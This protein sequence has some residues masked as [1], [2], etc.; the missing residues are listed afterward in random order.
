MASSQSSGS[1]SESAVSDSNSSNQDQQHQSEMPSKWAALLRPSSDAATSAV[2]ASTAAATPA[3]A[4]I[5][6]LVPLDYERHVKFFTMHLRCMPQGYESLDT[7]RMTL[8][9][10]CLSALDVLGALDQPSPHR[11]TNEQLID[12]I[13]AQQVHPYVDA[14]SGEMHYERCGFKGGPAAGGKFDPNNSTG[15]PP[16]E[17]HLYDE[18]HIA[19][20][21]TALCCLRILG[22]TTFSRVNRSALIA[23]LPFLQRPDGSFTST[24]SHRAEVADMRFLYCATAISSMLQDWSGLDR[25]RAAEFIVSSQ[26]HDGALGLW[27][28]CEGHGGSTYCAVASLVLMNRFDRLHAPLSL[29]KW[30]ITRQGTRDISSLPPSLGD[31]G[32]D[33][34]DDEGKVDG[35]YTGRPN[36]DS[37]TC[38]S[39][40]IGATLQILGMAMK[41][42]IDTWLD[43]KQNRAFNLSC[44][45]RVGGFG[46]DRGA[47]PDVLHSYFG[48]CGLSLI[49]IDVPPLQRIDAL[50]GYA[51]KSAGG[52]EVNSMFD[53]S[54]WR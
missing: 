20:T 35:G 29:L 4:P 1:G 27:K 8:L 34:E 30:C 26:S 36:K 49:G 13:Y 54:W 38:Y 40:W 31:D 47:H 10:F 48:L 43:N 24:Y 21:Y 53:G 6:A 41:L 14:V 2:A 15:H 5:P 9:Y 22:D 11:P 7:S 19:M 25:D 16:N 23:A 32:N 12:W 17:T 42:P 3:P 39:F 51:V 37:D 28:G 33:D 52:A 45:H 18:A 50:L 44:Q 46:K